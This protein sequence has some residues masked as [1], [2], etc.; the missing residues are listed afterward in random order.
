MSDVFLGIDIGGTTAKVGFVRETGGLLAT[1]KVETRPERGPG[2]LLEEV[3]SEARR[4]AGELGLPWSAVKG[5]GVGCAGLVSSRGG[6]LI[7]SPNL[8]GWKDVPLGEIIASACD[9]DAFLD[10]D[11]NALAYGETCVGAARGK[12]FGVFLTLGTGVGGGLLFDGKIFRGCNGFGAE[13]GHIVIDPDGPVCQCGNRGCL[14]S[15]VRSSNIVAVAVEYY[16]RAGRT[17]DLERM[18]G[19]NAIAVTPEALSS[20]ASSGDDVAAQVFRDIGRWLG[21][22]VGGF[23]NVFNPQ[24]VVIGGGVAQA[25]KS[26]LEPVR[27]WAGR[28]AFSASFNS[29][30]IAPASLGENGGLVGAALEARDRCGIPCR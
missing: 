22:A 6:V 19:G 28:Y 3:M 11:A 5:V 14:E 12:T 29:A 23:I 1:G 30:A 15:F 8:S 21:I 10:N 13:L 25:G 27:H 9:C 2:D 20:A 7:T 18:A 26:L 4:M 17:A 16:R 24:V